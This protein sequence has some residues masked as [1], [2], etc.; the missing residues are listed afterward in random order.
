MRRVSV[1]AAIVAAAALAPPPAVASL[2]PE[3]CVRL[4]RQARVARMEGDAARAA[5][6]LRNAVDGYPGEVVPLF[7]LLE[8]HR[9]F[10]GTDD[11]IHALREV[12]VARLADPSATLPDG[13]L[14]YLAQVPDAESVELELVLDAAR[15]RLAASPTDYDLLSSVASLELRLDRFEEAHESLRAMLAIRR[16]PVTLGRCLQL[17][18]RAGRD[19]E[20]A[21]HL[22]AI[23]ESSPDALEMRLAYLDVLADLGRHDEIVAQLE[24]LSAGADGMNPVGRGLVASGL[25]EAA[26]TLRDRGDDA[27]AERLFRSAL[28]LDETNA[29]A[30]RAL[31][32]LYATEQERA[33]FEDAERRR[34]EATGDPLELV[35]EGAT[36][37]AGGNDGDAY[38]ILSRAVADLPRSE[39]AQFN[40]GI[41]AIRL[42]EWEEAADALGT[43]LELNPGNADAALNLG[44]ALFNLERDEEAIQVLGGTLER[45]PR[46][47]QAH[48]YLYA[49]HKRRGEKDLASAHLARYNE[50]VEN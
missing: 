41:A 49:I 3:G 42:E 37:L 28:A 32:H 43:V 39:V 34:R 46:L 24:E 5:S 12:L 13:T 18:R 14:E 38:E 4:V 30:R 23:V 35:A 11:E 15:R 2:P 45:A 19:V 9:R 20:V 7:A 50:A 10:G 33:R 31:L 27:E 48:Y 47:Y 6:L 17:D 8:H 26:W 1:L 22:A 36:L 16:D 29:D 25:V 40:L 21:E 44:I